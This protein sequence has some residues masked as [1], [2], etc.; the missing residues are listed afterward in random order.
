MLLNDIYLQ[1]SSSQNILELVRKI[2]RGLIIYEYKHDPD[3]QILSVEYKSGAIHRYYDI[4]SEMFDFFS[5]SDNKE[6]FLKENIRG[7]YKLTTLNNDIEQD[8]FDKLKKYLDPGIR[9]LC[10]KYYLPGLERTDLYQIAVE[11]LY[12]AVSDFS[13]AKNTKFEHFALKICIRAK[14]ITEI[15][16]T[17][18]QKVQLLN[19]YKSID[20]PIINESDESD[21]CLSDLILDDDCNPLDLMIEQEERNDIKNILY[22]QLTELEAAVLEQKHEG[23]SYK[24]IANKLKI[25]VKCVDNSLGRVKKK[26]KILLNND[27]YESFEYIKNLKSN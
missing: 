6:Q 22:E 1:S 4:S 23:L 9:S 25:S 5:L 17:M 16:R 11:T 27:E 12:K 2:K 26:A 20:T 24:E 3:Y 8:S 10:S 14:F 18:A 19:N 13:E 21:Y 15:K 7:K